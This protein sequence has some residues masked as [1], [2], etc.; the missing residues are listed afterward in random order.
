MTREPLDLLPLWLMFAAVCAL[1]GLALEG[2]YRFSRWRQSSNLVEKESPV[3]A[4]VASILALFA[5]LLAFT[6]S[7]AA[8]RYEARR[9]AVLDESNAVGTTYLR[10][11]LLPEPQRAESARLL[12]EYVA[13]RLRAAENQRMGDLLERSAELHERLWVLAVQSVEKQPT[14]ITG[15][16][17]QS[18]N[19][20]IDMH[21]VRVQSGLRS[22]I[23]L[24]IWIGLLAI[25][26]LAMG[27]VGYLSG[28]SGT[29]RSPAM[30]GLVLAFAGVFYM[31]A[32]L[33]RGREGFLRVS[34]QPLI[35]LQ[36]SMAGEPRSA[37]P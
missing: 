31:I 7:M 4:M 32:D 11:R 10:T 8:T 26:M 13:A 14:P 30:L 6:F 23:P 1:S 16:Y 25:A 19:E 34:Q 12:R 3:G 21:S 5:F 18:L 20:M 2:G 33:D 15:L 27:S 29:R 28:L 17:V 24:V 35:D 22:R 36:N 9:Q 37:A